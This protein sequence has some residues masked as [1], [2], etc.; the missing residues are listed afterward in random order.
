MDPDIGELKTTMR[1]MALFTNGRDRPGRGRARLCRSGRAG[2][3]G[4][5]M[6]PRSDGRTGGKAAN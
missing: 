5:P 1:K 3:C 2:V 6:L 4:V